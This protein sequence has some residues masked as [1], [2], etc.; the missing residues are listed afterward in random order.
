MITPS[1]VGSE[2]GGRWNAGARP[3]LR[4]PMRVR[5]QRASPAVR[6]AASSAWARRWWAIL[7]VSAQQAVTS[8]ALGSPWPAPPHASQQQ[9]PE[10]D[11][12][13]DLAY[14]AGRVACR[15]AAT[16]GSCCPWHRPRPDICGW[17][18]GEKK[19][20]YVPTCFGPLMLASVS[21]NRVVAAC[22]P[23]NDC[24]PPTAMVQVVSRETEL[25][26]TRKLEKI[27]PA[28]PRVVAQSY[29]L[30]LMCE[31][32]VWDFS[33]PA[34]APVF[35]DDRQDFSVAARCPPFEFGHQFAGW[36]A[37]HPRWII[38]SEPHAAQCQLWC[39]QTLA[40]HVLVGDLDVALVH[41]DERRIAN[42]SPYW[43]GVQ[44]AVDAT[45]V[46]PLTAAGMPRREG[47]RAAGAALR[48]AARAKARTYPEL[49][50]SARRPRP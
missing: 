48:V 12:V 6:T 32:A 22:S 39:G 47:G 29:Q 45:L 27:A 17:K 26:S 3:L 41:P 25:E 1:F 11:R 43:G 28:I 23:S 42:G 35:Q 15:S 40:M 36:S 8:T 4:D 18:K 13:L 46:W 33:S 9:G 7:S 10:L 30:H 37:W 31:N 49:A 50:L 14:T 20:L 19:L 5:A 44:L 21:F 24:K 34:I 16:R 2:V 38:L